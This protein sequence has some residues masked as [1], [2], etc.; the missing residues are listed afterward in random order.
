M[1]LG[2]ISR[3]FKAYSVREEQR[4]KEQSSQLYLLANLIGLSNARIASEKA[5]FPSI[6]DVYPNL[7]EEE[8]YEMRTRQSEERIKQFVER[9]NKEVM[10]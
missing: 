2:E 7:F 6:E 5:K 10:S 3:Y 9:Y 8:V 4:V 1:D